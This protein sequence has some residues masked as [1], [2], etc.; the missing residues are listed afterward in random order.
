MSSLELDLCVDLAFD[1][2]QGTVETHLSREAVAS[3]TY[4]GA[5]K[6][7]HGYKWGETFTFSV[8][9]IKQDYSDFTDQEN[10]AILKWL[11]SSPNASFVDIYKDDSEVIAW[12]ALGNWIDISSYKLG[13]GRVVGY[14]AEWESVTPW[15]FSPLKT[16]SK[17]VSNPADAVI[18]IDIETDEPQLPI[19]PR[20][21]IKQDSI[22]SVVEIAHAMTDADV[23]TDG[24]VFYDTVGKK[25]YW[26]DNKG[27][28]HISDTNDSKFETTSTSIANLYVD[29]KKVIHTFN[30]VIKNNIKGEAIVLDGANRVVSS[31]RV[32]GRLFGDDFDWNW[33]P[34]REGTNTLSFVSNG[35]VKIE[36]REPIKCGEF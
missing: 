35:T 10:R 5:L 24:T 32:N 21:T 3:E 19:Y 6:R 1:G 22:T 8:T 16:V 13:N 25:Y 11:T 27:V 14:V 26:V 31:S 9:L 4:N 12:S 33:I 23:W 20:I 34:L 7:T 30:T 17:D 2:D 36:W 15:A 29:N 28:K 18:V